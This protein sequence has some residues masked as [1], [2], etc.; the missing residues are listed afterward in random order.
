V[1]AFYAQPMLIE[2][3]WAEAKPLSEMVMEDGWQS[4]LNS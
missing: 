3:G 2:E 4:S 1:L